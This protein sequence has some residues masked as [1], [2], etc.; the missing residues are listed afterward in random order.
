MQRGARLKQAI[1]NNRLPAFLAAT[2]I[3][4]VVLVVISMAV[5]HSSGAAQLDLS[6][7]EFKPVRSQIS[8][9]SKNKAS[10]DS[11]GGVDAKVLDDFLARFNEDA[12]KATN[13]KAFSV[14]VLSD[15]Q[16]GM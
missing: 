5:Y 15:E 13:S 8:N 11:Q 4:A 9:S 16:L 2:I 14:D 7:A 6:R 10:F 1:N 3:V 12:N